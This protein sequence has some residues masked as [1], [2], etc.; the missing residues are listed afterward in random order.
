ERAS[1]G[2]S[3]R[4]G[5]EVTMKLLRRVSNYDIQTAS[6]EGR[7]LHQECRQVSCYLDGNESFCRISETCS[8]VQNVR[9]KRGNGRGPFLHRVRAREHARELRDNPGAQHVR[10]LQDFQV[11]LLVGR[12][13]R[14]VVSGQLGDGL[15]QGEIQMG[16]HL[17]LRLGQGPV[18]RVGSVQKRGDV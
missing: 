9:Q 4:Q 16:L 11:D 1:G 5:T 13:A 7:R 10:H 17:A 3:L 15:L 14:R 2:R 18:L 8:D 6:R 12:D